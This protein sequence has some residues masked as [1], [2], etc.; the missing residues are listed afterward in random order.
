MGVKSCDRAG[1]EHIMCDR[2]SQKFGYICYYCYQE[3]EQ[4][5]EKSREPVDVKEFMDTPKEKDDTKVS[6]VHELYDTFPLH[7]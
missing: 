7:N 2:H 5:V 6:D 4:L 3:L 1:C